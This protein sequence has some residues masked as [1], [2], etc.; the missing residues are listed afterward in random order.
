[1]VD[2]RGGAFTVGLGLLQG[3]TIIP[4]YDQWSP[5]KRHRTVKLARPALVVAG[6]DER[7]ALESIFGDDHFQE[8]WFDIGKI[9]GCEVRLEDVGASVLVRYDAPSVY[10]HEATGYRS[11]LLI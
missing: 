10:P 1:M 9:V 3:L 2:N 11:L 7:T 8:I 6:V 4:H 5:D